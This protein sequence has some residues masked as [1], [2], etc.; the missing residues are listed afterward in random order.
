MANNVQIK[1]PHA[2]V[3]VWNYEEKLGTEKSTNTNAVNEIVIS[4]VSLMNVS[5]SKAKSNPVGRFEITLAPTKN[6]VA[7][8]TPGS[9]CCIMMSQNPITKEDLPGTGSAKPDKVKMIGKIESVRLNTTVNPETGARQTVYSVVGVDWAYIFENFIYLDPFIDPDGSIIG[10]A[11]FLELFGIMEGENGT[12]EFRTVDQLITGII[13]II[14]KPLTEGTQGVARKSNRLA[15]SNFAF[16][17]PP[18]MV[19]YLR[20]KKEGVVA[21]SNNV[22]DLL[23]FISG[24]LERFDDPKRNV[25]AYTRTDESVGYIDPVSFKGANTLW[26]L[27]IDNGNQVVNEMFTGMRWNSDGTMSLSL[28]NRIKPFIFKGE[29]TTVDSISGNLSGL[30][31]NSQEVNNISAD[32]KNIFSKFQNVRRF[33]IPLDDI[34]SINAGTNW[35]DK[36]NFIEVKPSFQDAKFLSTWIKSVAQTA[37]E[38]AFAREGFRPLITSTK[39][40]PK[41]AVKDQKKGDSNS[42]LNID[43]SFLAGWKELLRLWYFDT[44]KMLNGTVTL[45]GQNEHI[46]VG[47]NILIDIRALGITTN[48][49]SRTK[50]TSGKGVYLM[51]HVENIE[52]SFEVSQNGARSF[53]TNIQ[54]VRGITTTRDGALIGRGTLDQLASS[55]SPEQNLNNVNVFGTSA[56]ADPDP[57]KL[58]GS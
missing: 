23:S 53:V 19:K 22:A 16:Q 58:R 39:Q 56:G 35:R 6:W 34:V 26:Q 20:I 54:F 48:V 25:Q 37:D 42:S 50:A 12:P 2:A 15:K 24:K 51:A 55:L 52:H 31:L 45:S 8:L 18:E 4:T 9:W 13:D 28:Y 46:E 44:H 43:P 29:K 7:T 38:S 32:V 47:D 1:T 3:L 11:T 33:E 27:L 36:Y 40:I 10:S 17:I 41:A 57:Q 14:G 49:N 5:T 30:A 21:K